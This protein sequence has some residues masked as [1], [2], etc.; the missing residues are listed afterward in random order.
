MKR[1]VRAL[2]DLLFNPMPHDLISIRRV[3]ETDYGLDEESAKEDIDAWCSQEYM[4]QQ[5]DAH[6]G[7]RRNAAEVL[8]E[9]GPNAKV[10][11]AHGNEAQ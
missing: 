4:Q 9:Y 2:R 6:L 11:N 8:R 1:L 7:A 10:S 3:V 5:L